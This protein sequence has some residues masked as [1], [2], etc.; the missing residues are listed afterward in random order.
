LYDKHDARVESD[1]RGFV[2][3]DYSNCK[4][5]RFF[6]YD[7]SSLKAEAI[8]ALFAQR[9]LVAVEIVDAA[10]VRLPLEIESEH[11]DVIDGV[12]FIGFCTRC[13]RLAA[14]SHQCV[15]RLDIE[16]LIGYELARLGRVASKYAENIKRDDP[17]DAG[18]DG[19][20]RISLYDLGHIIHAM[21]YP[22]DL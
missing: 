5:G 20:R 22:E 1:L 3:L 10:A 16:E 8:T 12:D 21:R 6:F 13:R 2:K 14:N 17:F 19:R 4:T 18:T 15:T 7:K 11:V 9:G